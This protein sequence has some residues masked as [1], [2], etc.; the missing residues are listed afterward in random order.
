MAKAKLTAV[1]RDWVKRMQ[2]LLSECPSSRIGFA[3]IGD[4]EVFLFDVKFYDD[5][6]HKL[7]HGGGDFLPI[8]QN[9]GA[10][11]EE[12]LHFPNPVESTSG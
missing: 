1:E 9:M 10:T 3:T 8:A 11:F 5:I 7:D 12:S 6:C 4:A 2:K